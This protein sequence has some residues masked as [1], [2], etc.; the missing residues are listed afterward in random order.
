[1]VALRC[2]LEVSVHAD[3]EGVNDHREQHHFGL[4]VLELLGADDDAL[5]QHLHRKM[6]IVRDVPHEPHPTER[7]RTWVVVRPVRGRARSAR[8]HDRG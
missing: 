5:L 4:D 7:A 2:Y 1:M 6:R 8:S 3:D